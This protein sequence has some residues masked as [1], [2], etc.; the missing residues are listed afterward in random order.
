MRESWWLKVYV[1]F[2][3]WQVGQIGDIRDKTR[4]FTAHYRVRRKSMT[5]SRDHRIYFLHKHTEEIDVRLLLTFV[6]M[7]VCAVA[8][9]CGVCILV[10]KATASSF[11]SLLLFFPLFFVTIVGS[12]LISVRLTAP[13]HRHA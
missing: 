2:I 13:H 6:V 10:E 4:Y 8:V 1:I 7:V 11:V 9:L 5:I 3:L 12:W